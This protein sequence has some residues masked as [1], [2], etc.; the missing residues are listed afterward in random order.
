LESRIGDLEEERTSLLARID[1]SERERAAVEENRATLEERVRDQAQADQMWGERVGA[2]E[3]EA[4]SLADRLVAKEEESQVSERLRV[5]ADEQLA[6]VR[7]ENETLRARIALMEAER[8][9]P[10]AAER[11]N[12]PAGAGDLEAT[13]RS[14]AQAWADQDVD[15]YLSLYDPQFEPPDGLTREAWETQRRDRLTRPAFIRVTLNNFEVNVE[16]GDRGWVRFVQIY[17]SNRFSD[18]VTKRLDLR[19]VA[20]EWLIAAEAVEGAR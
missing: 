11:V 5:I 6:A 12:A 7:G 17:E 18:A 4:T 14:W 13:A 9:A 15:T 3:A 10:L 20:G 8:E 2:L 19:R 16:G 1:G